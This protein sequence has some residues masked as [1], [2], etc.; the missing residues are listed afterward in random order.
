[1]IIKTKALTFMS[2]LCYCLSFSAFS[3]PELKSTP[4]EKESSLK[5]LLRIIGISATPQN[6]RGEEDGD[7]GQVWIVDI[8]TKEQFQVSTSY[9]FRSPVFLPDDSGL[10]VLKQ[11]EIIEI[12]LPDLV[13]KSLLNIPGIVKIIGFDQSDSD[14]FL[15]LLED[16]KLE[17]VSFKTGVREILTYPDNQET[18]KFLPHIKNW[19]RVYGDK[20][21]FTKT[22]RKSTLLGKRSYTNVYF[23]NNKSQDIDLSRC[24]KTSCNQPSLSYD[25]T[26]VVF[27]KSD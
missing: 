17:L 5:I 14:R 11:D 8:V 24:K 25:G 22:R 27:I 18:D 13:Q 1:M 21:V 12:S 20:Q 9:M 10:L 6:M 16:D 15:I 23:Q 2:I 3:E 26:R 19:K 7:P 4:A